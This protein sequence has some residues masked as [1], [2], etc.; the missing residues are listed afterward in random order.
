MCEFHR[1]EY[2]STEIKKQQE[3]STK[4]ERERCP[5]PDIILSTGG[6]WMYLWNCPIRKKP[7]CNITALETLQAIE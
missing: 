3:E 6:T 4:M 7:I 2:N 1:I 5:M